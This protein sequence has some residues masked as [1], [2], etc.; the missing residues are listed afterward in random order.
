MSAIDYTDLAATATELLA[1]FGVAMTLSRASLVAPTYDPATGVATPSGP[2]TYPTVGVKLGHIAREADGQQV[3]VVT[4]KVYLSV[5]ETVEPK[6]G[7][8]LTIGTEVFQIL[9]CNTLA[10]AGVAV[11]YEVQVRR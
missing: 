5:A 2:A 7:D 10:P 3:R 9:V 4:Q 1:D 8:T 11:L 6:P